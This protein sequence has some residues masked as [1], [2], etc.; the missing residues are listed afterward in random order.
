[1]HV[2]FSL[3]LAL[4]YMRPKRTFQS[5]ITIISILGVLLGVAVLV[6]VT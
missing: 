4:K 5:V 3:F 6:I 1:M 2:P